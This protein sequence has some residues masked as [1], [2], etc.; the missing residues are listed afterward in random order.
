[1]W[2]KAASDPKSLT[3]EVKD[4]VVAYLKQETLGPLKGLGRYL[5]FGIA[6]SVLVAVGLLMLMLG[7]LRLLQSETGSTFTGNLSWLPYLITAVVATAL[8]A[9]TALA[10]KRQ[11]K[12]F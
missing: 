7:I 8:L 1:M 12:K 4:L 3:G 10:I 2:R 9:V 5:G 11:P 6:G